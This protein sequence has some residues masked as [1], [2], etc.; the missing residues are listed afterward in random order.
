MI[1]KSFIFIAGHHR[2]GTSLL[3][4]ILREHPFVS[5][6]SGTGVPEDEGQHLQTIYRP[7]KAYGGPGKY[8]FN[9]DA[10]MN[11][12]HHLATDHSASEIFR[13]WSRHY[14][15]DRFHYIEKSPPNLIR[16]RFLQKLFPNS[17]FIF[18]LRHPVAVSYATQKWS[19][20][21]IESLI[22]HTLVGYEILLKD[23]PR[24]KN[25]YLLR[26]E[27]FTQSPQKLID[28]IADFLEIPR[29]EIRHDISAG[30]NIKYFRMW[31]KERPSMSADAI[32]GLEQRAN[33]FGYSIRD[34]D[35]LLPFK[36]LG[37]HSGA[38]HG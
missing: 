15:E 2:S 31:L 36:L 30:I 24:I 9:K 37:R 17:K 19:K 14:N 1:S 6:F 26:Y 18:I 20:T 8:I 25:A 21:T 4:E 29:L 27:D 12:D 7:A 34:C 3:H 32:N 5:G 38:I 28:E 11:E 22:E 23:L 10:Y 35:I 33:L 16:S 13:Q